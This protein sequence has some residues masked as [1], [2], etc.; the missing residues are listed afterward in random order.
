MNRRDFLKALAAAGVVAAVGIDLVPRYRAE[1]I[2]RLIEVSKNYNIEM[3]AWELR[4][5]MRIGPDRVL[6]A[7]ERWGPDVPS[8][9]QREDF[10]RRSA[11]VL[12]EFAN[13]RGST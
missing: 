10:R 12:A 7:A 2:A 11:E 13:E 5:T 6:C 1:D 4:A 8:I 9:E 3:D